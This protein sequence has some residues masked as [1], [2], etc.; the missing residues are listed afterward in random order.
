MEKI[1]HNRKVLVTDTVDVLLINGL[2]EAG[3]KV[4]YK[5]SIELADLHTIIHL[6]HGLVINSKIIAD[7]K[8]YCLVKL[9]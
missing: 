8:T 7:Q 3:F 6:Y 5:P 1:A 9:S 2:R 4:E